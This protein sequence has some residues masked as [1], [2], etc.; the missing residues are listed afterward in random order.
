MKSHKF[1]ISLLILFL[2]AFTVTP[3]RAQF[4][5]LIN[6]AKGKIDKANQPVNQP[7]PN[8]TQ[9]PNQPQQSSSQQTHRIPTDEEIYSG[10]KITQAAPRP[11][12]AN[13]IALSKKPIDPKNMNASQ[14]TTEF[15]SGDPVYAVIFFDKPLKQIKQEDFQGRAAVPLIFDSSDS[16]KSEDEGVRRASPTVNALIQPEQMNQTY[17][18]LCDH[19]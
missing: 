2:L 6:K 15:K 19:A 12:Q 7:S 5:G 4:G 18:H 10:K 3:A 9:Q 16:F 14:F 8:N 17:F 1:N 11:G 13:S